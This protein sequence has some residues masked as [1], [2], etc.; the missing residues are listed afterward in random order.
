MRSNDINIKL[1][2]SVSRCPVAFYIISRHLALVSHSIMIQE[3]IV[4]MLNA[5]KLT[6]VMLSVMVQ[7]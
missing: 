6:I 2:S 4:I 5:N 1:R 3:L 7:L